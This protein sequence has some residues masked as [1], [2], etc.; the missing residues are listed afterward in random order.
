L[1][2]RSPQRK[3]ACRGNPS[4][5]GASYKP[6]FAAGYLPAPAMAPGVSITATRSFTAFCTFSKL[7]LQ[8]GSR[9]RVRCRTQLPEVARQRS[10]R[11]AEDGCARGRQRIHCTGARYVQQPARRTSTGQTNLQS[12]LSCQLCHGG[13]VRA[14]TAG[15]YER[16][17]AT[18]E[19]FC[20]AGTGLERVFRHKIARDDA[21]AR[22]LFGLLG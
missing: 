22:R 6:G 20:A 15:I 18:H 3:A 1:G 12:N 9:A 16:T 4:T 17:D 10:D 2:G 7:S 21:T 11:N 19:I 8:A 13:K 5:R 14:A